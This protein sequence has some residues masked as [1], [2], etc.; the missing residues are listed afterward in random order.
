M[1]VYT[2]ATESGTWTDKTPIG[3]NRMSERPQPYYAAQ[4]RLATGGNFTGGTEVDLLKL[5]ASA[6]NNTASNV[7]SD[8]SERGLPAGV[9]HGRLTTLTGGLP[10]NDAAQ[11][12]YSLTWE[13]RQQ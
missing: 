10:V 2:G 13:E 6:A 7:G 11:M 1:R 3:V 5:R 4:C 8:F 9:Y 12:T